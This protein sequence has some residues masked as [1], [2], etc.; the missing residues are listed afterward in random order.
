MVFCLVFIAVR[1]INANVWCLRGNV[2][3][4]NTTARNIVI[5]KLANGT[6]TYTLRDQEQLP[7]LGVYPYADTNTIFFCIRVSDKSIRDG[8]VSFMLDKFSQYS[9]YIGTGTKINKHVC[10]HDNIIGQGRPCIDE[11]IY[12]K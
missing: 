5:N 4:T 2:R 9:V 6:S 7:T 11:I 10:Y 3:I 12:S 8:L 1:I